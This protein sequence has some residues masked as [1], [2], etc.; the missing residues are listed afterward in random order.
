MSC[1]V[2][3]AAGRHNFFRLLIATRFIHDIMVFEDLLDDM[4]ADA[5]AIA[6]VAHRGHVCQ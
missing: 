6:V 1:R 2:L 5:Q 4:M 3:Y